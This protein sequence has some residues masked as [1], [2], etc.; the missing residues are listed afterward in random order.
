MVVQNT[1]ASVSVDLDALDCYWR[2]HALPGRPPE[3]SRHVILRRCLPRFGELFARAGI[4]A[5][6]FVV[7]RD[8]LDQARAGRIAGNKGLA[9][10]QRFARIER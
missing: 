1:I 10:Q 2:I 8:Q 6:F 5:T 9:F 3:E 7:G 4:K